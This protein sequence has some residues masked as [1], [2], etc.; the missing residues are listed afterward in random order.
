MLDSNFN[1]ELKTIIHY[2]VEY[3]LKNVSFKMDSVKSLNGNQRNI[4]FISKVHKGFMKAQNLILHNLLQLGQKRIAIKKQIKDLNRQK[5][6]KEI[7]EELELKLKVIQYKELV[8][9]KAADAIA[10]PLLQNDLTVIRR[11]Y[12]HNPPVEI[13]NSNLKHDIEIAEKIFQEDNTTFP[14]ISDLTSFI[15]VADLL[16]NNFNDKTVGLIELKEGK[17]NEEIESII[18]DFIKVKCERKLYYP[19]SE[20]DRKF[21]NQFSR[22]VKQQTTA[23]K[24]LDIINKGEGKDETTGMEVKIINDTFY[25]QHFDNIISKMLKEVD[26]KNYSLRI[27][28]ECLIVGVY[29]TSKLPIHEGFELWKDSMKIDF[30]T[31]NFINYIRDPLAF[32][33]YLQPFS[34]DDI[35]KLI[36]RQKTILLTLDIY[37]WFEMFEKKGVKVHLLSKKE[38]ARRNTVPSHSKVFEYNGQAIEFEYGNMKQIIS[39]GMFERM[40]NQFLN[41]SSAVD[42]I[43]HTLTEGEKL[44]KN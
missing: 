42:F 21:K 40:F 28:D 34:I 16:V 3:G 23:F 18:D 17:V 25:T 11:L 44:Y 22:Y 9:R 2:I 20:K 30:P 27:F 29:N 6:E 37:K 43:K 24:T 35:V 39:G 19:L 8:M 13:F 7:V 4:E 31:F 12:K 26:K 33:L 36:N 41:P 1:R 15:Q 5:S 10:W 14:L 38:T 32:P